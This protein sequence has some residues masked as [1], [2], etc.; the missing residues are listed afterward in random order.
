MAYPAKAVA[1]GFLRLAKADGKTVSSMKLLK[2]VFFV[3]GWYLAFTG[4]PPIT[5]G[6]TPGFA[7]SITHNSV[8]IFRHLRN[9][10]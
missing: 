2:L 1:N 8:F 6:R 3:H 9:G 10:Q 7:L 5:K 4:Q